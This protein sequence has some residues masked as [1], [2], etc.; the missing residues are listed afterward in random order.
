MLKSEYAAEQLRKELTKAGGPVPIRSLIDKAW[1]L[2]D[3]G[4]PRWIGVA[5]SRFDGA[6]QL[7]HSCVGPNHNHNDSCTVE[8][9]AA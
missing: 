4:D 9:V 3:D 8:W 7:R 1:E 6:G 5:V 2:T